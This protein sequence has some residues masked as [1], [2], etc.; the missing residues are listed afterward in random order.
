[1]KSLV[2]ILFVSFAMMQ[3]C[4]CGGGVDVSSSET[5]M[6]GDEYFS[7]F[8]EDNRYDIHFD[9][10]PPGGRKLRVRNVGTL[11]RT[12]NDSNYVHL[13]A[14][15]QLGIDPIQDMSDVWNNCRP[16]VRIR[17]NRYYF[18]DE[19]THSLPF[20]VPEAAELLEDISRS[21]V[22]TL[23]ARG[24]GDYRLKV[25]SVLRTPATVKK[26]RRRN[27]NAA[28]TSAHC[29]GT[30][31][32]ISYAKFICD[33]VTTPRT[34]EDMKNLLGEIL[35]DMREQGRCF[36]KY[37]RKQGCFHITTRPISE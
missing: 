16:L 31:F 14:A 37:E 8:E 23:H 36:V 3:L 12:F 22:D 6:L 30:T 5:G 20:L 9:S 24:G 29:F 2:T 19:L 1:M 18:V 28:D 26:L 10:M 15:R 27:R 21:W 33:S 25:T 11:G 4:S 34:Q 13:A 17:S 32:D 7:R 35:Y